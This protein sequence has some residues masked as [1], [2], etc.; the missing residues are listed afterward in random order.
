MKN[1]HLPEVPSADD[2]KNNGI[3]LGE[4]DALLLKKIEELTLYLIEM[5]KQNK[6]MAEELAEIKKELPKK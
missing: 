4:T 1:G 5:E 6:A 2:V 3:N